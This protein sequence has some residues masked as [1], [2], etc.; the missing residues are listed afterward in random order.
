MALSNHVSLT[1]TTDSVGVARAGFGVPLILSHNAAW[2]ERIR[3]YTSVSDVAGDFVTTSPEYLAAAAM[4]AQSPHPAKIAI[5]RAAN[6]PTQKY[7]FTP[8]A[9]NSHEYQITVE[10]EGVTTTTVSYTSDATATVAEITAGLTT[11]LNG[12]TGK[13]YTAVDGATKITITGDSA[14][15]WFSLELGDP[16]S[17][18][19]IEQTHIDPGVAADLT[20]IS[21]E[22]DSWYALCTLYNSNS[23]VT[24]AA[25]WINAKKKIYVFAVNES[26][27]ITKAVGNSDTLD[28]M[29]TSAYGRVAGVYHPSPADF[30]DAAWMGRCLPTDAG[31]ITWKFKTLQGVSA[32]TMTETHR[33]NLVN[34]KA[35]FLRNV[36]GQNIMQE[37]TTA[38]GDFIDVQRGIDWL[39]DDMSKAVFIALAG[40]DKIPYTDAGVAVV[41]AEVRASLQRAVARGILASSPEPTVSVPTVAS[42]ATVD[43]TARNLPDVKFSGTLA[44]AIHK[45]TISGVVSV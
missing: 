3:F 27:A 28:D 9:I 43:K 38:D 23:L 16:G 6:K 15:N 29:Y 1:I 37:G 7:E 8:I 35:N 31:A 30:C 14:G 21:D 2:V 22:D 33:T 18:G 44:G 4:F 10:G 24:A 20:A 5:G 11:Q 25:A 41:E 39:D 17:E 36:A 42:V 45:A 26:E 32:I 19:K 40:A 13:N 34:R 12:V